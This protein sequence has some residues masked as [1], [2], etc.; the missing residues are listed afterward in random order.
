MTRESWFVVTNNAA[1]AAAALPDALEGEEIDEASE[2][3]E[4]RRDAAEVAAQED[5]DALR[6]KVP[7]HLRDVGRVPGRALWLTEPL[8]AAGDAA[9]LA[10]ATPWL[11]AAKNGDGH[12]VLVLPGLLAGDGSTKPLRAYIR[13]RGYHVRG[14]RLGRNVGP[15][16]NVLEG[17]PGGLRDLAELTGGKVSVI[18]WSMGGIYARQLAVKHPELIRQVITLGTPFGVAHG[19]RTRADAMI[20]R[21]SMFHARPSEVT[22]REELARELPVPSTSIY[23]KLDGIVGWRSCLDEPSPTQQNVEVRCSHLGFGFDPATLW[24]VADRLA[25]PEDRWERFD[26]PRALRVFYGRVS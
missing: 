15:S 6:A 22:P 19:H 24:A 2:L 23:S 1:A 10:A 7:A 4:E 25:Q 11:A 5:P 18:G 21:L 12:G 20:N 13:R 3:A 17:L 26:P 8:R 14:W 9:L 16:A